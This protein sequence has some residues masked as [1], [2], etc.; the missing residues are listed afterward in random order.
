[1]EPMRIQIYKTASVCLLYFC[2]FSANAQDLVITTKRDTLNCTLGKLKNDFYPIKFVIEDSVFSGLIHK[3]SVFF[4]KKDVFRELNNNRL[5]PWYPLV[6]I[7]FDA[8]FA[9]HFGKFRI[10]DDLTNKGS[11]GARTGWFLGTDL[12]YYISKRIGYGIKYNYRSLLDGDICYQYVGPMMVFRFLE[13]KKSGHFFFNYSAGL[14][15][16][17]QKNAPVQLYLLRP[18]IEMR[19]RSLSGNITAGY[20]FR[21]SKHVSARVQASCTMG[22]PSFVKIMGLENIVQ[23]WDHPLETGGYCHNMNTFH[24][25]A[26]FSFHK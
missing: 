5:R 13:R 23:P 18:R 14:G 1:M 15:W 12:T 25:T 11:F 4:F 3:D 20:S 2:L 17:V 6:E 19:A 22:Y 9:H 26:G 7:G 21:L 24:L 16:M 8:G 10:D